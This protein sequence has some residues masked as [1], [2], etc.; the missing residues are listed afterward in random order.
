MKKLKYIPI[1]LLCLLVLLEQGRAQEQQASQNTDLNI[2]DVYQNDSPDA[3]FPNL[4]QTMQQI[5]NRGDMGL[6]QSLNKWSKEVNNMTEDQMEAL[7]AD[8]AKLTTSK[9]YARLPE[10][11]SRVRILPS[12]PG[13]MEKLGEYE[14]KTQPDGNPVPTI[15]RAILTARQKTNCRYVYIDIRFN[16]SP[17]AYSLGFGAS[18]AQ[19][20]GNQ[21]AAM[22]APT[23]GGANQEDLL[24]AWIRVS[25]I[26]GEKDSARI[27]PDPFKVKK[28]RKAN[29][30]TEDSQ[31]EAAKEP[32]DNFWKYS[33][34]PVQFD[35]DKSKIRKDQ[36]E[37]VN[38]MAA[39]LAPKMGQFL[40]NDLKVL[41]VGNCDERG[42]R[43]YNDTLG[44][45]RAMVVMF[46]VM[47][48]L[49]NSTDDKEE[50]AKIKDACQKV[51]R[52]ASASE[53]HIQFGKPEYEKDRR[54]D[55]LIAS[56][57]TVKNLRS[58][59]KK[60]VEE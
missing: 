30:Q 15:T 23:T 5:Y 22:A 14:F 42:S 59:N 39:W 6:Y 50:A 47:D 11:D 46:S 54:T 26:G 52:A 40:A 53:V 29:K 44:M 43:E 33:G 24:I 27:P 60:G 57:L 25:A 35:F 38:Q 17:H 31:E 18:W 19:F 49:V 16:S 2:G 13:F 8:T 7:A 56:N 20:V 28:E 10:N 12:F 41:F 1:V 32:E 36:Q 55:L 4:L 3:P 9:T 58:Q 45:E 21:G 51:F 48:L 34:K 37:R